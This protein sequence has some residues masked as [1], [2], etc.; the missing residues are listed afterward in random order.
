MSKMLGTDDLYLCVTRKSLIKFSIDSSNKSCMHDTIFTL[1]NG[2]EDYRQIDE[3]FIGILSG[4][5]R[6]MVIDQFSKATVCNVEMNNYKVPILSP[7]SSQL[8]TQSLWLTSRI[9]GLKLYPQKISRS[10]VISLATS[11][12]INRTQ[13]QFHCWCNKKDLL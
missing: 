5:N 3:I 6:V 9:R 2:I 10:T 11:H 8:P 7:Y 4:D 13:A 12:A 1:K